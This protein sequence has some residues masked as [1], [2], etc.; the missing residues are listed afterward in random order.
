MVW[1]LWTTRWEQTLQ[2]CKRLGGDA[3]DLN[4]SQSAAKKAVAAVEQE[5]KMALPSSFRQVLIG[6]VSLFLKFHTLSNKFFLFSGLKTREKRL[7]R[8]L[9]F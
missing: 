5:L 9:F 2:A 8:C 6:V 7:I 3:R 1:D 4:I